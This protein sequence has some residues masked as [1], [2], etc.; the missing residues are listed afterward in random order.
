MKLGAIV[1]CDRLTSLSVFFY[2]LNADSVHLLTRTSFNLLDDHEASFPLNET[3]N[4]MMAIATNNGIPFPMTYLG[5]V[6]NV[7]GTF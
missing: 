2:C 6:G 3:D 1:K 5:P 7:I 4:T